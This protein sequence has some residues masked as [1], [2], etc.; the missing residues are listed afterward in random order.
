MK[1]LISKSPLSSRKLWTTLLGTFLDMLLLYLCTR[2]PKYCD[3]F[4][5]FAAIITAKIGIYNLA[6]AHVDAQRNKL[7]LSDTQSVQQ[8]NVGE[9]K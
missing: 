6:E 5:Y 8:V 9:T 3:A 1:T 7:P 2:Y 4:K